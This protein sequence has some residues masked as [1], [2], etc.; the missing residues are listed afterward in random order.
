MK[1]QRYE[2]EVPFDIRKRD[3]TNI[4]LKHPDKRPIIIQ[5]AIGTEI[6]LVK[7]RYLA[8]SDMSA[9]EFMAKIRGYMKLNEFQ[10]IFFYID[11]EQNC[12]KE[13]VSPMKL[14]SQLYHDSAHSDGFL[15]LSFSQE[16]VFG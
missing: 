4:Q 15:Y 11:N 9:R 8:Q 3:S 13:M 12:F 2:D 7:K 5:P 6:T 1:T 16:N 10:A 14:I